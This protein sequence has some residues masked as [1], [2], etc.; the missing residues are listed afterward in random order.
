MVLA[1]S[2]AQ[3]RHNLDRFA[4]KVRGR[5]I[6]LIY[7]RTLRL[8]VAAGGPSEGTAALTL[9]SIDSQRI[10]SGIRIFNNS[11]ASTIT[12]AVGSYLLYRQLGWP[13]VVPLVVSLA[14]VIA[15]SC[16]TPLMETSQ[17]TL[18]KATESR[19]SSFT[20]LLTNIRGYRMIDAEHAAKHTVECRRRA[21]IRRGSMFRR[22]MAYISTIGMA[23]IREAD[24]VE[25]TSILSGFR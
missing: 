16:I 2:S 12:V 14:S 23:Q 20:T 15:I 21:E 19:V 5:L 11:W 1:I 9:I 7:E 3:S 4:F 17:R 10:V 6:L 24:N 22:I 8:R 18:L 25:L 13:F